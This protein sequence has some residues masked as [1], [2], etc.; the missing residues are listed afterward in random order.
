MSEA[1]TTTAQSSGVLLDDRRAKKLS[2][3][4]DRPGLRYLAIWAAMPGASGALVHLSVGSLW[5]IPAMIVHG[6]ILTVPAYAISTSA[7]TAP[8]FALAG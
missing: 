6:T 2:R 3:R 8:P 1:T 5:I 4:G 7:P